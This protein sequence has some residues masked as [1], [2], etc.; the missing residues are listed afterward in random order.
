MENGSAKTDY[1][2]TNLNDGFADSAFR[3]TNKTNIRIKIDLGAGSTVTP[4]FIALVGHN[5]DASQTLTVQADNAGTYLASEYVG[6]DE[7]DSTITIPTSPTLHPTA[8]KKFTNSTAYRY[9][10]LTMDGATSDDSYYQLGQIVLGAH[11]EFNQDFGPLNEALNIPNKLH[12]MENGRVYKVQLGGQFR[13]F[14]LNFPNCDTTTKEELE[15]LYNDLRG[16]N[17]SFCIVKNYEESSNINRNCYYGFFNGK[18]AMPSLSEGYYNLALG[19]Q[20]DILSE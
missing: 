3:S 4:T 12:K 1:P 6:S 5:I 16:A 17:E 19:F 9:F 15:D 8:W 2:V 14:A 20:E 18:C 11:T 13:Q 10:W 7:A